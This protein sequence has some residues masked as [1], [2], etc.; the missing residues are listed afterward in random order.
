MVLWSERCNTGIR[1]NS[2]ANWP[3]V[4]TDIENINWGNI[5]SAD[6]PISALNTVLLSVVE[7]RIPRKTVR[8][9][10][11]DKAWFNDDCRAA[12]RDKQAAYRRWTR[13]RSQ[14]SWNSYERLRS[15]AQQIYSRAQNAYHNH[16][17]DILS[18]TSQPHSWWSALKQSLFG[19]D[20]SLPPLSCSDGSICHDAKSKAEL[21]SAT[22]IS[23][24]SEDEVSL[25]ASCF[26]E[27]EI[28]SLAF[29]SS[30]LLTYL[31]NLDSYGGCDPLVFYLYF[32]K[33]FPLF[34]LPNLV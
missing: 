21:L 12:F 9:R 34:W 25:P 18:G 15:M 19:V 28:K 32:T 31:N 27:V 30:E 1:G 33:R 3:G 11:N 13:T 5:Y 20:S 23:K 8:S 7:R 29:K 10:R 17:K 4:S 2:R 16:L 6:C 22:F 14:E 26:P 24:Q